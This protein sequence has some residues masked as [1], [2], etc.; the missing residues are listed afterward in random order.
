M[1]TWTALCD[2]KSHGLMFQI[3]EPTVSSVAPIVHKEAG[4]GFEETEREIEPLSI[5]DEAEIVRGRQ[6]CQQ[7]GGQGTGGDNMT[8]I[9]ELLINVVTMNRLKLLISLTQNGNE[10]EIFL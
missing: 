3:K 8:K 6:D 7:R 5:Q 10:V 1:L 9:I 4:N 2:T